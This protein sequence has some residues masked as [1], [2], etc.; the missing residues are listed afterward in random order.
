MG[1]QWVFYQRCRAVR[2]VWFGWN[3]RTSTDPCEEDSSVK[4]IERR[5]HPLR[6]HLLARVPARALLQ[7][8]CQWNAVARCFTI[9]SDTFRFDEQDYQAYLAV[10]AL[11]ARR[12]QMQLQGEDLIWVHDYHLFP[13]AGS[14][15][16][17]GCG[18]PS[19]F[20]CTFRFPGY[21]VLRAL[22]RAAELLTQLCEYDLI[23]FQTE[24]DRAAFM[25][26][27]SG[28]VRARCG[29]RKAPLA[30]RTVVSCSPEFFR[31]VWI[32]P[33]LRVPLRA[34]RVRRACDE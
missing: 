24:T 17:S 28:R 30:H 14:F 18:C 23:G 2:G 33:R 32:C 4:V 6:H 5:G 8:V 13:W 3:G 26:S 31:S 12:L 15:D 27:I 19:G 9:C 22:P 16:A 1:L 29:G 7:L 10:N 11:F 34:R 25:S 21:E 20:S